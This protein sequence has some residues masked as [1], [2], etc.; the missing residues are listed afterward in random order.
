MT[1]L[2]KHHYDYYYQ[3]WQ[4]HRITRFPSPPPQKKKKTQQ[5]IALTH[6]INPHPLSLY[7]IGP[8]KSAI[9]INI[10]ISFS[11]FEFVGLLRHKLT[12]LS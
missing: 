8:K 3:V 11:I 10:L 1:T 2:F 7:R 4:S 6:A 5:I 12:V 9:F